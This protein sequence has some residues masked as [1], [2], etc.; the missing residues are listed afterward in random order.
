MKKSSIII[1]CALLA[2]ICILGNIG[3]AKFKIKQPIKSTKDLFKKDKKSEAAVV[4][5]APDTTAADNEAKNKASADKEANERL[6]AEQ[7]GKLKQPAGL[8]SN[9]KASKLKEIPVADTAKETKE[10]GATVDGRPVT[11]ITTTQKFKASAAFDQQI[12]LNPSKDVIYPGVVL[13]GSSIADGTYQEITKGKKRPITV[14]YD[15][16]DAKKRGT[17]TDGEVVG[18]YIPSL[19]EY[20][21]LHNKIMGQDISGVSSTWSFEETQIYSESD[22]SIKFNMGVGYNTG[23]VEAKVNTGFDFSKG[24]KKNKYIVKFMQTFYTVNV[25]Q[26]QGT[27]LYENFNI[28]DFKNYRP[29]YVSSIAYGR[30]A[31]MTVETDKTWDE[32][33]ADLSVAVA[34]KTGT[35]IKGDFSAAVKKVNESSKINITFIGGSNVVTNVDGFMNELANGGFSKKNSG[36][37][38]AYKLRFVDDNSIANT[39]YN[40]EYTV[41][42]TVEQYGKGIDVSFTLYKIKTNANDGAGKAMELFGNLEVADESKDKKSLWSYSK[43]APLKIKE[44]DEVVQ[45]KE[46]TYRVP[47]ESGKFDFYLSLSE[48]DSGNDDQFT[49][50]GEQ[51]PGNNISKPVMISN[52]KDGQD[53]VIKSYAIGKKNKIISSEWIEYYIRVSKKYAY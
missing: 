10:L 15:V 34:I 14:S 24:S 18:T 45:N 9:V 6:L 31:Y 29:V 25:D 21:K 1:F 26:G 53:I 32:I 5:V 43:S 27:F 33:K 37:I 48:K 11:Y 16:T 22:F 12:M 13:L 40:D 42:R 4:P 44:K 3:E 28:S 8:D 51:V 23:L 2:S 35:D 36:T 7:L 46:Y 17:E 20:S 38:I 39:V 50:A 30:M 49:D 47:N 19:S 41:T 52:L